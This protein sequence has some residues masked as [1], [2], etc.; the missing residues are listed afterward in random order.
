MEFFK[1]LWKKDGSNVYTPYVYMCIAFILAT[2][3]IGFSCA[4]IYQHIFVMKHAL[5]APTVQ[6]LLG[7]LGSVTGGIIG[8]GISMIT[9]TTISQISNKPFNMLDEEV[10]PH[11]NKITKAE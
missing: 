11:P 10:T 1:E 6:L 3:I 7:I 9:R 8:S 2:P 4:I 5:D